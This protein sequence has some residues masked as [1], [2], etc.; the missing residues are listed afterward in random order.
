MPLSTYAELRASVADWLHRGTSLDAQIPD[1]IRMAELEIN[2]R[3][4][5][6]AQE[7]ETP[8]TCIPGSRF[9][10]QPADFGSPVMLWTDEYG[11]RCDLTM[12]TAATLPVDDGLSSQP[13]YWAI[14][15]TNVA[16]NCKADRP[17][18]MR[19]RYLQNLF[20]SDAAPTNSM[21]ARAPDLYLYGALAQSAPY[22]A[23]D[24][25]LPMWQTKFEAL[26]RSVAVEGTRAL[27]MA[28]LQTELPGAMC[29][30]ANTRYW[31]Y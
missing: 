17:Y 10:P 16:F 20:L 2:R 25:R 4:K 28:Q 31:G 11:P 15:G 29:R 24:A 27:A 5:I 14:D 1:F 19:L 7:V 6:V 3:L 21:F 22:M 18:T 30:S 13:R 26:M 8:L 9:V 12:V 23:D